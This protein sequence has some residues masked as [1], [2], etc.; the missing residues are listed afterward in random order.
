MNLSKVLI[1]SHDAGGAFLLSKWC[2]D[3]ASRLDFSFYLSG[4]AIDIFSEIFNDLDV[5]EHVD[6]NEVTQVI[7][8]TGW[9]TEFEKQA[10]NA[11]KIKKLYVVSYLDH[12]A[13]YRDRFEYLD[14]MVYPDEIWVADNDAMSIAKN[15][16]GESISKF[17]KIR[18]RH[19]FQ[20]KSNIDQTSNKNNVLICLEPIRTNYSL[21]EAYKE[22][23]QF[24]LERVDPNIDIVIRDHP[25]KTETNMDSLI[26]MVS[27]HFNVAAS[28]N[29]LEQDLSDSKT[30]I[31]YQSS[32]LAYAVDLGIETYSFFPINKMEP[33]LP[34]TDITYISTL[35][36]QKVDI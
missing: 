23:A 8:S 34:H 32:V 12:W 14:S 19:F 30:V 27:N 9:Q 20:I 13:N 21:S 15:V 6:W 36:S 26:N 33:I 31:G 7:T 17:R 5:V 11:A 28:E 22:L 29:S 1:V 18:N 10:I 25:S 35:A 4:P 24:L 2:R 3:W 16:F